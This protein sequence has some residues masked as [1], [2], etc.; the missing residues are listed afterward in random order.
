M[1]IRIIIL[2]IL[3]ASIV[4]TEG[5]SDLR[6]ADLLLV[7]RIMEENADSALVIL[8][9]MDTGNLDR[10]EFLYFALLYTQAQ[11]KTGMCIKSDSLIYIC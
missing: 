8:D 11:V 1:S 10:S 7:E 2:F 9:N 3:I 4:I 5:C 6:Q